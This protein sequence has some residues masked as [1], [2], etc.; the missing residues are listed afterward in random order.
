MTLE[1]SGN[2]KQ[3][4]IYWWSGVI[5][6]I[7]SFLINC[8]IIG[9]K[10]KLWQIRNMALSYGNLV[11]LALY[12]DRIIWIYMHVVPPIVA[13]TKSQK[14]KVKWNNVGTVKKYIST[15][16]QR[17]KWVAHAILQDKVQNKGHTP[18]GPINLEKLRFIL[19]ATKCVNPNII[20]YKHYQSPFIPENN[21]IMCLQ[22]HP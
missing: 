3:G 17:L 22:F 18:N 9:E 21:G 1:C 7:V 19:N 13:L 10:E 6:N 5:N 2:R 11:A 4:L 14:Q 20:F 12:I 16:K 8:G 15:K